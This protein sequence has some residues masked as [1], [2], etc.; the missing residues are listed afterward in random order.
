M[1]P[2]KQIKYTL[3]K[4]EQKR[5]SSSKRFTKINFFVAFKSVPSKFS[6]SEEQ[7]TDLNR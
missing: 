6:G 5:C 1:R 7:Y 3:G 4:E 2:D